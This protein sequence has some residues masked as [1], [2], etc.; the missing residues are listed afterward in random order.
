M[1]GDERVRYCDE[2][3][4][5][6]YNL[7][8]MTAQEAES[9]VVRKEGRLCV[10]FYQRE[11][12]TVM[13]QDCP[14]GIIALHRASRRTAVFIGAG[15]VAMFL[16]II[17]LF[18]AALGLSQGNNS[19]PFNAITG[20]FNGGSSGGS[21]VMGAPAAVAPGGGNGECPG[22][23]VDPQPLAPQEHRPQH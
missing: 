13:T 23:N 10:R 11:D 14:C 1:E 6:V 21:P 15:F 8:A 2:C 9:L 3:A 22:G 20:W 4:L 5:N 18:A 12:G 16:L 7:S 17:G 19:S